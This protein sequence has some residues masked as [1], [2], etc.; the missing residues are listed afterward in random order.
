MQLDI[1]Y[2]DEFLVAINKPSGLLVHRS[3]IDKHETQFAMQLLRDQIG[4]HVFPV[5]RLDRPTSGVLIFALSSEVARKLGEQFFQ[6]K[7]D[8]TYLAIVR[9]HTKAVGEIDYALK[10]KLDKIADKMSKQDKPA[11]AAVTIFDKLQTFELPFA[12]GRYPSARYSLVKLTPKTGRKHQLRRHL[13]HIN[14]PIIGDTTHGDGK[15]NRFV[16]EH[17]GLKQLALTCKSMHFQHPISLSRLSLICPLDR[18]I[19]SLLENW[20]MCQVDQRELDKL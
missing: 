11:Q 17:Y 10:E 20:G 6:Q 3:L 12:V 4:Q 9:G 5:H 13:A 2:Q 19:S 18:N 7:V 8:K 15:H 1:I 16:R 14:H